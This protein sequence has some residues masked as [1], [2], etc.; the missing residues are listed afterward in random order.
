MET[1][2]KK[3]R[4]LDSLKGNEGGSVAKEILGEGKG[5][6]ISITVKTG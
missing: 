5:E 4:N 6:T 2:S 1:I 3:S